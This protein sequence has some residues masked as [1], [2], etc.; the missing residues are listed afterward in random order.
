DLVDS[1]TKRVGLTL[2][3]GVKEV[4]AGE[5]VFGRQFVIKPGD[6]IVFAGAVWR[7]G[8]QADNV[9]E[10]RALAA[11]GAGP[12]REIR[13]HFGIDG[14]RSKRSAGVATGGSAQQSAAGFLRR[15]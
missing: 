15:D 14:N 11:C 10:G 5:A 12:E 8:V 1:V 4:T 6:D 3:A 2:W 13:R 7:C 9:G